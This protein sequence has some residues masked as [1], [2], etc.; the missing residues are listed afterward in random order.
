MRNSYNLRLTLSKCREEEAILLCSTVL[1]GNAVPAFPAWYGSATTIL[2]RERKIA[3]I[4]ILRANITNAR[5]LLHSNEAT[6]SGKLICG[7]VG[8]LPVK[9]QASTGSLSVALLAISAVG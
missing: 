8:S 5:D 3:I 9:A 6:G 7:R 2:L 1:S 4:S